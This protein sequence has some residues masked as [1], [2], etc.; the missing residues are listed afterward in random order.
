[1][2]RIAPAQQAQRNPQSL[3]LENLYNPKISLKM[4]PLRLYPIVFPLLLTMGAWAQSADSTVFQAGWGTLNYA[5]PESPAF[6][7]LGVT[8]TN[9]MRP[10]STRNIAVSIGDYVAKNGASI[11]KN[12][13]LEISPSLFNPKLGL[14]DFSKNRIWYT[15]ALSIGTKQNQDGS[16][17]LGLGLKIRLIDESDLRTNKTLLNYFDGLGIPIVQRF[18]DAVFGAAMDLH[19]QNPSISV[20]DAIVKINHSYN[21][22]TDP[23]HAK[24]KK[25]IDGLINEK[26]NTQQIS[27]F[28]E[29]IKN[30]TWNKPVWDLGIAG[31]F[32]SKDSLLQNLSA[33]SIMGLWT[34]LGI[35]VFG[36]NGQW[37]FG[38][39][40]QYTDSGKNKLNTWII[41]LGT[42]LYYGVN[43]FKG[44]WE[45]EWNIQTGLPGGYTTSI[46][47]ETTFFGGLWLD[48]GLG[49][50][51]L[52]NAKVVFTPSISFHLANGEKK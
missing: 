34:T 40:V 16:Y 39:N 4:K 12:L 35:P 44:Y 3:L 31:L 32:N 1:M 7:I 28:R 45:G 29:K 20:P 38:V 13:A 43:D 11:P 41:N 15:S 27:V 33:P 19:K 5:V 23:D 2:L 46:G 36:Q 9:I 14:A 49:L 25:Q 26:I 6:K 17:A 42:R 24:I 10:S 47:I 18:K 50:K 22:P 37:L 48:F 30:E 52:G 51:K 8:P 21:E